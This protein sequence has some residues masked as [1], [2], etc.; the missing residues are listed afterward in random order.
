MCE[1]EIERRGLCVSGNQ[2]KDLQD[3][4]TL[5][6][7]QTDDWWRNNIS[8]YISLTQP[9]ISIH[10]AAVKWMQQRDWAAK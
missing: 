1:R 3:L 8:D 2:M 10:P 7:R 6:I 9:E 4:I 5:D